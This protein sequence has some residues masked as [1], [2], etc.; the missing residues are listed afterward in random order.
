MIRLVADSGSTK[1]DWA[2]ISFDAPE[3]CFSTLGLNPSLMPDNQIREILRME[4][5][6]ILGDVRP[7]EVFFYGA[8]C[9]K[10]IAPLVE[11]ALCD[12]L[13][14]KKAIVDTD[15]LGAA[16]ALCGNEPGVACI[17]GTGS[18]S[19]VYDGN[20]IADNISPLGYILGD[21]GSGA[22]IGKHFIG[23]LFKRQ[24]PKIVHEIFSNDYGYSLDDVIQ[25][26]YRTPD[27][28]RFLASFAPFVKKCV[29]IPEVKDM[30]I[31]EFCSFIK[32]NVAGYAESKILP[33]N[34][35]GS[36]AA[37]FSS[38]LETAMDI[39]GYKIGKIKQRPIEGIIEYHKQ[40]P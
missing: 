28:N 5:K 13:K 21:E 40:Q 36:I 31:E 23:D 18:N 37:N 20:A 14:C 27:A 30:V 8:G 9:R 29:Y 34:F 32:R 4:V 6:S 17:L 12:E 26:V 16:R 33:V 22:S 19:C 7:D 3:I 10:T 2:L 25:R 38:Q 11:Y 35:V 39:C 15:M 24:Y 1:T